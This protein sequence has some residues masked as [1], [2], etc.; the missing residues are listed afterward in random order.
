V[1]P[2]LP[3][4]LGQLAT[5]T[6]AE[7]KLTLLARQYSPPSGIL[8]DLTQVNAR[9]SPWSYPAQANEVNKG[10][11]MVR[12]LI[13]DE[14]AVVLEGL[15]H[16]LEDAN[17]NWQ[18]VAEACDGREAIVKSIETKPDVAVLALSLPHLNGVELTRTIRRRLPMTEVVIFTRHNPD[19]Q[20]HSLREA[21]ARGCVLKSEPMSRL[22]DAVQSAANHKPYF[23]SAMCSRSDGIGSPL[24]DRER[25]VVQLVAEGHS[26]KTIARQ[27]GI[28]FKTVDTHRL[29]IMRKLDLSKASELV[30]YAVRHQI[31]QA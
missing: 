27:L 5:R 14:H 25:E 20:M 12:I 19:K 1:A 29:N 8:P 30:R 6:R 22:V 26:S 28:S 21:G 15:R 4:S 11:R 2:R 3:L 23:T 31:A 24:T 17:Q 16:H 7:P 13:A 10:L 18:V 9:G